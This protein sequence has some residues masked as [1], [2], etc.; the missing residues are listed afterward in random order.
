ML[1]KTHRIH[2]VGVGG[3]GMSGI[4]E[5][6][7]N[8]GY[9]V[10]GSD[11]RA[12]ETTARLSALGVEISIGHQAEN[13]GDVDVVVFT[14]AVRADNPE[15]TAARTRH[16]PV[17]P[18]AELLGELMRLRFG[19][20]VAGAHGKTSTTSMIA[21]VLERAGLDPTALIGGRLSA[22][23]SNARLGRGAYMVAEADESDRSFL[24]LYPSIAV[25]TNIDREHM[26]AYGSFEDLVQ[27]F[28][29]FANKVPF[30]G[31]V[32]VCGDDAELM[33]LRPRLT[34]RVVTYGLTR[35]HVDVAAVDV[36]LDGFGSSC[37]VL[38]R[39]LQ[40]G[41]A[42]TLGDLRLQ[43]PGRHSVQNA[44]AAVAVGLELD[45]PFAHIATGLAEFQG[46]E[47]RFQH[48]G[49]A[50]GIRI[51]DDYG[52][53]PTEIAAVLAAARAARPSRVIVAFQPHRYTRTRDLMR[54]FGLAL[55]SADEV[56]LTD[57]YAA[58]EDPLPGVT[59]EALAASINTSRANP[60]RIVRSV[61]EVP[62]ALV[63]I[64][65]PGDLILTMGA[66]SIGTVAA[67]LIAALEQRHGRGEAT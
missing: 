42:Q 16:I 55:A 2:F 50:H 15:L 3:I 6:L 43:V 53:H 31:S 25:M 48:Y 51:V 56:V 22:F 7:A 37:T 4:S 61:D 59:V 19:I 32:I 39:H 21:L 66:G 65:R 46:A 8:L 11:A 30:Y 20:A 5:L 45:V 57:I 24:K 35:E 64:A 54:E 9:R 28:V 23:G 34:R 33:Q 18:R 12:S 13:V 38:R 29:E 52:H 41:T 49:T 67:R 14:S 62:A 36:Q 17:I 1:G 47:R 40:D 44:L 60:V 10:S 63:E 58:G 27:A 26:E